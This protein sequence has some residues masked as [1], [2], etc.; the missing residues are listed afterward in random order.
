MSM[1]SDSFYRCHMNYVP[2]VYFLVIIDS[3]NDNDISLVQYI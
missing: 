3:I 1:I 2:M